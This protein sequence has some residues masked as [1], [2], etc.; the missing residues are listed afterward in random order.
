MNKKKVFLS[1]L[2][3]VF[4]AMVVIKAEAIVNFLAEVIIPKA[5]IN[6]TAVTN[7]SAVNRNLNVEVVVDF[8]VYTSAPEAQLVYF[9]DND[10]SNKQI[11]SK[12]NIP[13]GQPFYIETGKFDSGHNSISY[14]IKAKLKAQNGDE[15][16]AY[17]PEDQSASSD[18]FHF[19]TITSSASAVIGDGGGTV[20]ID[21]GDQETGNS[22]VIV[23][24][25]TLDPGT[26]VIIEELDFDDWF[27]AMNIN[28]TSY[29]MAY[30]GKPISGINVKTNPP[31]DTFD[32]P[33]NIQLSM[34]DSNVTKF[35][36]IYRKDASVP[37]EEWEVVKIES[38]D[39]SEGVR[40]VYCKAAKA[41]QYI[42][43]PGKDLGSK[44]YKPEKRV[45]VKS[46]ISNYGGFKFNNLKDGDVVKIYTI[47]G[48]KIAELTTGN[49]KG[50]EWKG[51]KGTNNSGDWAESGTY[52]YQIKLKEEGKII[53]GTIAFV[54]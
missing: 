18:T 33:L 26:E 35:V 24:P 29:A 40:L 39:F 23:E 30:Y 25:G 34:K 51:R 13:N 9:F 2:I 21:D 1:L 47:N 14:Q 52:I 38:V 44:D 11:V 16:Y 36:V 48:K 28:K 3:F 4:T 8:G 49:F 43:F 31:Q 20:V 17:W 53:S 6:H 5:K 54:W 12:E 19:T 27:P 22:G 41:G 15:A 42:L 45:R 7:V 32:P 46:R 37:E 10:S 50:F